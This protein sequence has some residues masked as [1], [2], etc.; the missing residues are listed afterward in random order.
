MSD[1][2]AWSA[3]VVAILA[4][5]FTGWQAWTAHRSRRADADLSLVE[6]EPAEWP[7]EE[8]IEVRSKGPDDALRVWARITVDGL[9]VE[10]KARRIRQGDAL[11][12][13]VPN[14]GG[15]WLHHLSLAPAAGAAQIETA[16]F[17][18]GL[19]IR[20]RTRYGKFEVMRWH[21]PMMRAIRHEPPAIVWLG[22]V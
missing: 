17:Q 5:V 1:V 4:A 14:L 9:S 21:G 2:L 18:Y 13:T 15:Y 20:W 19:V 16:A 11:R 3:I 6:W 8:T 10:A 7:S 22:D 12:F